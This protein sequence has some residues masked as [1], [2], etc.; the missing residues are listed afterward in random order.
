MARIEPGGGEPTE[1]RAHM[2]P[3][4][5]VV[6]ELFENARRVRELERALA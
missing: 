3:I 6:A 4:D 1:G 2:K 5:E